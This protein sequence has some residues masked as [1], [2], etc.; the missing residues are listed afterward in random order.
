MK[1]LFYTMAIILSSSSFAFASNG[2]TTTNEEGSPNSTV[3]NVRPC[4]LHLWYTDA[5]GNESHWSEFAGETATEEECAML[6]QTRVLELAM[7]DP[8]GNG[9]C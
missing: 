2:S 3:D 7:E 4:Y 1:K 9:L 5:L 6:V 8:C